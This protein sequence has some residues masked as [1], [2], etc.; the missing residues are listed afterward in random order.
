AAPDPLRYAAPMAR[1][2]ALLAARQAPSGGLRY[3]DDIPHQPAWAACFAD[4]A[5]AEPAVPA[6][7]WI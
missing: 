3:A 6:S 1:A 5:L 7:E 4:Q 2:A